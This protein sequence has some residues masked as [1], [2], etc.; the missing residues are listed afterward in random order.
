MSEQERIYDFIDAEI[1]PTKNSDIIGVSLWPPSS[2]EHNTLD[3]AMWGV[4]ENKTNTT[5]HPNIVLLEPVIEA[6]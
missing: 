4:L 1:P 3:Y 5:S 6:E 2:P